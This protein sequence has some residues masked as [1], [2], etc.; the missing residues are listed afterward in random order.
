MKNKIK[1]LLIEALE[2][3]FAKEELI[4][5]VEVQQ[6]TAKHIKADYFS[7]IAMKLS[8]V[9]K[10]DPMEIAKDI[11]K[12]IK[13]NDLCTYDIARPGYINFIIK[14][15]KKNNIVLEILKNKNPI[16]SIK[17][18]SP[19]KI[20]L[21]FVS[22]NPTGPLHIGHGR[23]AI[24]GNIIAK[25]LRLQGHDVHTEY[26][27]ND[28]GKQMDLLFHSI[29]KKN[30]ADNTSDEDLYKGEYIND[31]AK[32]LEDKYPEFKNV[33]KPIKD[34]EK[35]KWIKVICNYMIE[36]YIKKDFEQLGISFDNWFYENSLFESKSV[37]KILKKLDKSGHTKK[38]EGAL[39]LKA[40]ELRPLIKSNGDYT[41]LS[42]DLAY[43]D[44]KLSEFDLVINIWGADHHGYVPRIRLGME[45][46]GHNVKKLDIHLIQF[47]N[48]YRGKEKISMSTRKGEFVMLKTLID[49]IGN[50]AINFFYL[51]KKKDQHLDF[52]LNL[53]IS[54]DK[55]NPVYY[56]QYAHARIEKLLNEAGDYM[57]HDY[58]P[59]GFED[60]L[61]KNLI[62]SMNTFGEI[63]EKSITNLE[64]HLMT[65]YLQKL[66]QDFHSYYANVKLLTKNID[67]SKIYL[68]AAVQKVLKCGLELL[69]IN[70][71]KQM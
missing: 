5:L 25:F 12:D 38:H 36:N 3:N 63:C 71:P 45:A 55:N 52:D 1:N 6:A 32:K 18:K 58:N 4:K 54:E 49:E 34:P 48:L 21:E 35:R 16:D 46:L 22:A 30:F 53:A 2:K 19:K 59:D 50:D 15:T 56:I 60:N 64:P 41:Y 66:A 62:D 28:V 10:K 47:A 68:I 33:S 14:D 61:E 23:G 43:H 7:N 37:E 24:Y 42:S 29:F 44:Y 65:H 27:I 13:E 40:D 8:K 67:Y 9:L 26:Y 17:S 70:A 31:I 69:N 51:T 20:H 39:M 11:L 57:N